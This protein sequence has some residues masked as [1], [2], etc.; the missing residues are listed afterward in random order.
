MRCDRVRPASIAFARKIN[1]NRITGIEVLKPGVQISGSGNLGIV[2]DEK[3]LQGAILAI[4]LNRARL[5][6]MN[7]PEFTDAGIRQ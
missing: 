1:L 5:T 4:H 7:G 6:L 2:G 3:L